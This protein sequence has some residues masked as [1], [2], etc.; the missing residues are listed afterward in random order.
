MTMRLNLKSTF[1][2]NER[3]R[4]RVDSR[5]ARAEREIELERASKGPRRGT[6]TR[7]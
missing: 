5:G 4:A 3:F 2:A 1:G 6:S 7:I